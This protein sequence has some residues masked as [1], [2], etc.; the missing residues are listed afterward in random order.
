MPIEVSEAPV[1]R[2]VVALDGPSGTG[3]S[4]VARLLARR[5]RTQYLDTGAMYRAATVAVLRAGVDPAD[6]VAVAAEV[7]GRRIEVG[8]DPWHSST[9]LDGRDVEREIR[10]A[11]VTA[12]VSP[13]SAV[14][15]VRDQLVAQ[16]RLIIG[17]GP[18]V[19]EGRDIG[20]VV[21]PDAELKVYLTARE[22]VRARRRAGELGAGTDADDIARIEQAL[23][24]RDDFDSSRAVSPLRRADGATEV[25]TSELTVDEVVELL[26]GLAFRAVSTADR[27]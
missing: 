25:D 22:D 16:Q 9:R 2:G 6:P 12:A 18:T 26:A 24:R 14:Q 27:A 7:A 15:A 17:R 19:A 4:T 10:T 8:T 11:A 3:K 23:R 1:F 21:W 5:L 13:V 20:S